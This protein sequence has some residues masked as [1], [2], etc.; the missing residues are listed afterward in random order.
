[1]V[2]LRFYGDI[3][4]DQISAGVSI[5][6]LLHRQAYALE[7]GLDRVLDGLRRAD[8]KLNIIVRYH[9]FAKLDKK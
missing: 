9:L 4:P 8:M 5:S 1:M 2:H 3:C 7:R 6:E